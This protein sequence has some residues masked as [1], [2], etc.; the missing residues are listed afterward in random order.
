MAFAGMSVKEMLRE[1]RICF[2]SIWLSQP[3][4][5]SLTKLF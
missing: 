2:V 3:I 1:P 4:F 5:T